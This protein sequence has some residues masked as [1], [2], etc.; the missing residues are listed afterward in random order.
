M[1]HHYH[2]NENFAVASKLST[3]KSLS[4]QKKFREHV[5]NNIR[6]LLYQ[7]FCMVDMLIVLK[8]INEVMYMSCNKECKLRQSQLLTVIYFI[9]FVPNI[10]GYSACLH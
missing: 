2:V 8:T 9:C 6:V 4:S 1:I 7:H 10:K 3:S 5:L